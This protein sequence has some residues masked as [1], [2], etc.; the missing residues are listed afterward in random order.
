MRPKLGLR[1]KLSCKHE[2]H[3]GATSGDSAKFGLNVQEVWGAVEQAR[4]AGALDCL[5]LLHFH[6]GSQASGVVLAAHVHQRTLSCPWP[7]WPMRSCSS[8]EQSQT[9]LGVLSVWGLSPAGRLYLNLRVAIAQLPMAQ[10]R[11]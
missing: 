1:A 6:I 5:Q 2:G 10:T 7:P 4:A 3:W 11:D 8:G 9:E